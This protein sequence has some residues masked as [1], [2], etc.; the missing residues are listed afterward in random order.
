MDSFYVEF[1][2]HC[3]TCLSYVI[4][5]F[6]IVQLFEVKYVESVTRIGQRAREL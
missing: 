5:A 4:V 2:M 3:L 1:N 6:D